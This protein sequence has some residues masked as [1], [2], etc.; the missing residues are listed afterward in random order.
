MKPRERLFRKNTTKKLFCGGTAR[1]LLSLTLLAATQTAFAGAELKISDDASVNLGIGLRTSYT[2]ASKAAPN[3]TSR[4]N[5][6]NLENVRLYMSGQYGKVIK[7]TFNTE[8]T[9]GPSSTGGDNVRVMDAIVQFEFMPEFNIWMG[10]MLPPSD[11]SNLDGP[12]YVLP[13]SYPGVVSNYTNIAVGRDNGV[14]VWG[15]PLGGKLVYAFGLFEGHNKNG[16]LSGGSDKLQYSGRIAYNILDPEPAPAYYTGSWYGGSKDILTV[17]LAGS[18]QQDGA[19]TAI[20][21]GNLSIW[22]ADILFEKKIPGGVPT[23][24]GAYY[25]YKVGAVDCGSGEPGAVACPV[26]D[27][28]GGQVDGKAY[29]LGAGFLIDPKVGWGQ[30]QPFVRFQKFDRSLSNTRSKATDIGVNYIIKG[31]NA[32]ISAM[33]SKFDDNRLPIG[34]HDNN[35][36]TLGVQ[37]QY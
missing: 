22:S 1:S 33:Y 5:D 9:G 25:K 32:K 4:S 13:W 15:K 20:R 19:G 37:L 24:E 31:P 2:S 6:F 18:T 30:F 34:K 21:K 8:R 35:Q 36:F 28:L 23:L 27:N 12:F 16:A 7:A 10:R 14:M 3:G 17:A 26:G 11:R 29:L